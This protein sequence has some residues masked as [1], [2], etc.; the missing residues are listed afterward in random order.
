MPQIICVYILLVTF[1]QILCHDL[2][3]LS[4]EFLPLFIP[5]IHWNIPYVPIQTVLVTDCDLFMPI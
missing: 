1:G 2:E 5:L 3:Q 4:V